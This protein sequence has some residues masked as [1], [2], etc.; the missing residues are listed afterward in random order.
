MIRR[1]LID[2]APLL[3]RSPREDFTS[4]GIPGF[5]NSAASYSFVAG[6]L[7]PR[8]IIWSTFLHQTMPH[9]RA[10]ECES[11]GVTVSEMWV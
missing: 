1:T 7:S 10:K 3:K 6:G 11:V 9:E 8:V 5:F 2:C 4:V